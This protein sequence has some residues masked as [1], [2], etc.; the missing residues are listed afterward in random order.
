MKE[1]LTQHKGEKIEDE[2]LFRLGM[3]YEQTQQFENAET[4][5]VK[6]IELYNDE[7][8]ADDAHF[9]LAKLYEIRLGQPEKAKQLYEQILF[10]FKDSIYFVEARKRYRMLRGDEIN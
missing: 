1:I 9:K 4:Q 7:I 6:L 10:N 3:L 2:A 8:L 5:Y